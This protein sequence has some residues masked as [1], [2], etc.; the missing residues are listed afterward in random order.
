MKRKGRMCR[1]RTSADMI[2]KSS[3]YKTK[4]RFCKNILLKIYTMISDCTG[5]RSN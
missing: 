5:F 1:L 2:G 3:V 4:V